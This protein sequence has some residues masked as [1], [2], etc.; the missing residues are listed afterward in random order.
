MSEEPSAPEWRDPNDDGVR[1]Y[2]KKVR[3][4]RPVEV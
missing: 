3:L 4:I 2:V 1:V